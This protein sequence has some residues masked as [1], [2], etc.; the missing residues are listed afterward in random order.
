MLKVPPPLMVKSESPDEVKTPATVRDA[1]L[2]MDA[3]PLLRV[4][5]LTVQSP[6]FTFNFASSAAAP[7]NSNVSGARVSLGVPL[8]IRPPLT[9][10]NSVLPP[11]IVRVLP[12]LW[13]S[14]EMTGITYHN[15]STCLCA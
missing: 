4:T 12:T 14:Y 8:R 1:P 11:S 3:A 13:R 7:L 15:H 2:S 10:F 9:T 6:F 5:F